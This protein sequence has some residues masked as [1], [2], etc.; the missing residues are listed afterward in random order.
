MTPTEQAVIFIHTALNALVLWFVWHVAWRRSCEERFRQK[1]FEVRDSLFDFA[2][3]GGISF[4][5]PAYV[6]LRANINSMIRFSHRI[7]VTR[8]ATFVLF[9]RYIGELP[10]SYPPLSAS[11]SQ[12]KGRDAKNVLTAISEKVGAH[13]MRFLLFS[14]PQI[15]IAGPALFLLDGLIA[16]KTTAG[17]RPP[18]QRRFPVVVTLIELQAGD[19]YKSEAAKRRHDTELAS[20]TS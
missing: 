19:A 20:A 6:A 4:T 17:S 2:R 14:S 3:A 5:D 10:E 9:K 8:L 7:S 11:L 16:K 12:I 1:L 15:L 18:S 13:T